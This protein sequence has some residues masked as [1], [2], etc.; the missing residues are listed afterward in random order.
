MSCPL[1]LSL[2]LSLACVSFC[3]SYCL[4]FSLSLWQSAFANRSEHEE[5]MSATEAYGAGYYDDDD[6]GL[7]ECVSIYLKDLQWSWLF[8]LSWQ[9]LENETGLR[10]LFNQSSVC[11]EFDEIEFIALLNLEVKQMNVASCNCQ[12]HNQPTMGCSS[13][14]VVMMVLI[15][16]D[17]V[18]PNMIC[19]NAWGFVTGL[20]AAWCTCCL[21]SHLWGRYW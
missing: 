6:D 5:R 14:M 11:S 19:A 1:A 16:G 15:L 12:P 21:G 20:T 7:G 10:I 8:G 17:S 2:S 18:V 13:V 4:S 9:H 3:A